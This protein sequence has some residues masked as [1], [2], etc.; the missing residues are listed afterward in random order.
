M[1][2]S[3]AVV[4]FL[5]GAAFYLRGSRDRGT[6]RTLTDSNAALTESLGIV[7]SE[8]V[9]LAQR[10]EVLEADKVTLANIATASDQIKQLQD[11]LREHHVE[12][13]TGVEELHSDLTEMLTWLRAQK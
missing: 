2:T 10:I 11:S 1:S 6:I 12:A 3:L 13:M 5:G 7:R 9:E 8:A 4:V